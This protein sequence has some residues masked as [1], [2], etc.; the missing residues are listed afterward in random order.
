MKS[1]RA[2]AAKAGKVLP[3]RVER[4]GSYVLLTNAAAGVTP[5]SGSLVEDQPF[6]DALAAAD[7]PPEVT[8]LVYADVQRLAPIL[9]ALASLTGNGQSKPPTTAKLEKFGTLVAFGARSG[10]ISRLEA[11]LTIH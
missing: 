3:L 7:V 4:H 10:S 8:W 5:G 6:K 11:R 2:L 9:Q 1:L